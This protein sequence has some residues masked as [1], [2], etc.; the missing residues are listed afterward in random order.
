M[1]DPFRLLGRLNPVSS[2]SASE[3]REDGAIASR[4][5]FLRHST[6]ITVA[7]TSA[8]I[9]S[10]AF[11][12]TAGAKPEKENSE[13]HGPAGQRGNFA[14]IK[15]HEGAHVD[16]LVKALG[17]AARPKPNF[18]NLLQK[19]FI[20][21]ATT[22][23]ALENTGVGAYLGAAPAI[24]NADILAA[25]GS[26]MTIEARHAGYLNSFLHDPIT[27]SSSDDDSNSNFDMPL[28]VADIVAAVTPFVVDLN[29]GP[30]LTY[31]TT[32]SAQNDIAI[33]NFALALEYL[34]RDFYDLN[35]PKFYKGT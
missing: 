13:V 6:A 2:G 27:A 22:A 21:F 18:A 9:L 29:G 24:S 32:P 28:T 5:S 11:T 30:P 17:T 3:A 26:I 7:G 35:V 20:A 19:N 16:Y 10:G 25:A 33:L 12:S 31:S 8:A 1:Q 14:S 23:Q 4:R 34:E 15:Q